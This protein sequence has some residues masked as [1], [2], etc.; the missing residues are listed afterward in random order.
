MKKILVCI[1]TII[2]FQVAFAQGLSIEL[3][4]VWKEQETFFNFGRL[5]N[6][7][8]AN[9]P[10]LTITYKNLTDEKLYFFNGLNIASDTSEQWPF[11]IPNTRVLSD[12]EMTMIL[13]RA[14]STLFFST[15]N[16]FVNVQAGW[17]LAEETELSTHIIDSLKTHDLLQAITHQERKRMNSHHNYSIDTMIEILS[18]LQTIFYYQNIIT[19]KK[20]NKQ[21]SFFNNPNKKQISIEKAKKIATKENK[22][23][24]N[25]F[26]KRRHPYSDHEIAQGIIPVDIKNQL[27]FLRPQEEYI[28]RFNLISFYLLGGNFIFNM[29]WFGGSNKFFYLFYD[30]EGAVWHRDITMPKELNGYKFF[31][32]DVN[33]G[34]IELN[35]K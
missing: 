25:Q 28:M 19:R 30:D 4:L 15:Y 24:I 6:H 22:K 3:S 12:L 27:V 20:T 32:E 31:M 34:S 8:K 23:M 10:Y 16:V 35:V 7:S 26:R 5:R 2:G 13:K 11:F 21:L 33:I 18:Y 1:V 9:I 14:D 17:G 29:R